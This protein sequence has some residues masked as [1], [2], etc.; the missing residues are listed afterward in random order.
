MQD[1]VDDTKKAAEPNASP[2]ERLGGEE[3]VRRVVDYFYDIMDTDP[4]AKGIR[5]MHAKDLTPMRSKLSDWVIG[6]LGGPPLYAQRS[7]RGCMVS[8]H[9]AF[10]IGEDERDQWMNCLRQAFI[11]AE[12]PEDLRN[13][14]DKPFRELADQLRSK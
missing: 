7:D 14:L 4:A 3:G 6:A 1:T 13:L 10:P 11:K 5:A 8:V 12:V 2:F 9:K